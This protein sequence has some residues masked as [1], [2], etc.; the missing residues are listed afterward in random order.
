[1]KIKKLWMKDF[2]GKL[3]IGCDNYLEHNL[4][5]SYLRVSIISLSHNIDNLLAEPWSKD[6]IPVVKP[7]IH[8]NKICKWFANSNEW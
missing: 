1:M 5:N 8:R 4:H 7:F 6:G 3:S 2:A